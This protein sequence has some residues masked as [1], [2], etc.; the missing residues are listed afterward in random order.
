MHKARAR[1]LSRS[2]NP[3]PGPAPLVEPRVT[4]WRL[5]GEPT[6]LGKDELGGVAS[7]QSKD[8][9]D[10]EVVADQHQPEGHPARQGGR[11]VA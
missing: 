9:D 11:K 5:G 8:E 6:S 10:N 7:L 3:R 1:G 4:R 2:F